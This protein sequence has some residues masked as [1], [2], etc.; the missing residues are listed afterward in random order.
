MNFANSILF[1]IGFDWHSLPRGSVVV[2]VGGGIGSTSMLLANAFCRAG[3]GSAGSAGSYGASS[4]GK[5]KDGEYFGNVVEG[6][7]GGDAYGGS[8]GRGWEI[9][10]P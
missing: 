2:D 6:D 7:G 8:P 9:D 10:G 1:N 4:E 3:V 5:S